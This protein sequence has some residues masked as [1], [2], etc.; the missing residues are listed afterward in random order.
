M[1]LLEN[2]VSDLS[3]LADLTTLPLESLAHLGNMEMNNNRQSASSNATD[4]SPA[5]NTN[6][7]NGKRKADEEPSTSGQTSRSKRSRYISQAWEAFHCIP[8]HCCC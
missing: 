1:N 5:P 6:D 4:Q 7:N 8:V 2:Q 3:Y